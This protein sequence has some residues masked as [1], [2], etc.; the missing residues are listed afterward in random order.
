M[1]NKDY[2]SKVLPFMEEEYFVE[3][4]EK[5][6]FDEVKKYHSEFGEIPHP[7]AVSINVES[8]KDLTETV[9]GEIDTFLKNVEESYK[10]VEFLVKATEQ[11]CRE[12]ATVLAIT[13]G[14]SV[15]SGDEKKMDMGGVIDLLREATSLEFDNRIGHDYIEDI[16]DR[17]EFYNNK[18]EKLPS[19]LEHLDYILRGG[20]PSKSLGVILAGTGVGKS[21]FMCSITANLVE[22]GHN[23]LYIT[24]EMAEEKIAQ[25]IDQNM[26]N[27]NMDELENISKQSFFKRF[28]NIK[29]KTKGRLIVKEYPTKSAHA[30]HFENLVK[31]LSQ[32]KEFKPDL[33]CVDYLNICKSMTAGKGANSYE[34]SKSVAE[35]LRALAMKFDVPILTA[36]QTNRSGYADADVDMTS[37]SESF[38][39]PMTADYMFALT[40]NDHMK[41]EHQVKMIQLKNRYNDPADRRQWLLEVDYP[42][43]KVRDLENQPNQINEMNN[44]EKSSITTIEEIPVFDRGKVSWK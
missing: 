37:T 16:E 43:M 4:S 30:G 23:V 15:L 12:R 22:T 27:L 11:W 34:Q 32:K 17:W 33:I 10:D 7:K 20:F 1:V 14:V 31:D 44:S 36:T 6:M 29:M 41:E 18:E 40:T 3:R 42:H 25:R 2:S 19:G 28:D 35:E 26:L 8:R 21:L 5:I 38:G 9:Y 13:K 39:V 24:M